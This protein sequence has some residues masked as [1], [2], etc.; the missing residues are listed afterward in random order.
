MVGLGD[1][2][3]GTFVSAAI[4]A[5]GDGSVVVGV[6]RSANG[7]EAFRWTEATGMVGLG[8]LPGGGFASEAFG[9]SSDGSVI[10]GRGF[11]SSGQ[12]AFRWTQGTGMIGLGDL[13]G[14]NFDSRALA[15]STDGAVVVGESTSAAGREAFR[16]T[17]TT[18]MVGLG[19]LPG[20]QFFSEAFGVSVDGSVVVGHGFSSTG[21]EA[22]RWTQ[23]T[24]MQSIRDIL[25][26]AGIDVTGW[27]LETANAVSAD[28]AVI[29]G[30]G[31]NPNGDIEAW[32]YRDRSGLITPSLVAQSFASLSG[33]AETEHS[34]TAMLLSGYRET[35]TYQR[36]PR[37]SGLQSSSICLFTFGLVGVSDSGTDDG[38][39]S[40]GNIGVM[41]EPMQDVVLGVGMGGGIATTN[42][43][44]DSEADVRRAAG[45]VFAGYVPRIGPQAMVVASAAHL[46]GDITRGYFNANSPASSEGG[47]SGWSLGILGRLGFAFELA[48]GARLIPFA[49][50]TASRLELDGW[51]ETSGPFAAAFSDIESTAQR[52]HVG[53]EVTQ[54]WTAATSVWG[55]LAWAHRLDD[56]SATI[57]G[58][59]IGLF[60]MIVTG[61]VA[62]HD[63]G[64]ASVGLR[65]QIAPGAVISGSATVMSDGDEFAGASGRLG[66]SQRF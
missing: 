62:V 52:T 5:N 28:G 12:E 41:F 38:L 31:L 24:G 17:Q 44:A 43:L 1:L 47:T 48:P 40:S 10:V 42:L 53:V 22:F 27:R 13:P 55:S 15:I 18:G 30:S 45:A 20:G 34:S 19:D 4:A 60:D 11:S 33:V 6:S 39:E 3:G 46:D 8:D 29:V 58:Q 35:A 63:W 66:F 54:Q 65:T 50:Y 57:S 36:C 59:I 9:V 25:I 64:E 23:A 49:Q 51:T 61:P 2:P 37:R 16:W 26:A 56:H 7:L 14:G 32:F 21:E